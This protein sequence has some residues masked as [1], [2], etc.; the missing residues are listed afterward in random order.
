MKNNHPFLFILLAVASAFFFQSCDEDIPTHYAFEPYAYA[1][2]DENGGTWTPNLLTSASQI[3]IPAPSDA[4][5]AE[6]LAEVAA[7]KTASSQLTGDQQAAIDYWAGDGLVRWNEIARE[8][9]TKYNLTP[10]PNAD[11]TY[12]A[13]DPANPGNYPLFPFSHPPYASRAFAYL[14]AAQYDALITAWHYKYQ[15]N[16]PSA[17]NADATITPHLPPNDLP[18]YPSEGAVIAAVSKDL[19]TALFPLE[20]DFIAAKAQEHQNSLIWAGINTASDIAGGDSL[21]RAVGKVFRMRA[22]TDGMKSAQTP[23]PVSDSIRDA[24]EARWGWHW[25]NMETPQRPVGVTPAFGKV[26]TWVVQDVTTV[27]PAGPPAPDSPEFQTAANELNDVLDNLTND[28]RRIAN[29]WSDGLN[30]YTPPGHWN[31]FAC[32]AII[33]YKY[34]PL[35]AARTLAYL[36]MAMQDAGIACWDQKY[37]FHYPRPIQAM[38]GFKTILGTPNFPSYTSGHSMFSA[39][40]AEVLSHVFPANSSL[41]QG[42]AEEAALSRLY[43]GIHYRFDITDGQSSGTLVGEA[44]VSKM[45]LDGG[46]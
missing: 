44:V 10:A 32:E 11:G 33:E 46:E 22:S 36:N 13:P 16:R 38:P 27:R 2:L 18:G 29:F 41:Y 14:S 45:M 42:Y 23:K 1:S 9:A 20:K 19:L 7:V 34:N 17:Y 6:F 31:R 43:G 21:G 8:M 35:R 37:Y 26:K 24:A 30:T 12:P 4:G 28:Q 15:F 25:I 39:A 5:S 3:G 40:G